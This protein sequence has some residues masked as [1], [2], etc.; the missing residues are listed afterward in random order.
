MKLI[1]IE[2]SP[3]TAKKYRAVFDNFGRELHTDFGDNSME[4][5]TQHKDE[6]RRLSY[7][8]RHRKDL[9]TGDPTRAGFLSW[10]ILWNTPSFEENIRQYKKRF[11]L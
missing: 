3:N 7:R 8:L 9:K 11:H 4:D 1:R 10:Y 5:F 6:K 2:K